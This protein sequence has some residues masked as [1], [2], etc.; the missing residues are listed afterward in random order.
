MRVRSST[1][2]VRTMCKRPDVLAVFPIPENECIRRLS[3]GEVPDVLVG[4]SGLPPNVAESY[5][6]APARRRSSIPPIG[7]RAEG[8]R[9][10]AS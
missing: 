4:R 3:A 1:S 10:E 2:R 6:S 8:A 7:A 5:T 9:I